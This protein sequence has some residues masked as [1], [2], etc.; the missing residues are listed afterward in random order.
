MTNTR[1]ESTHA[2][3]KPRNHTPLPPRLKFV[4]IQRE[5]AVIAKCSAEDPADVC[6]DVGE[7]PECAVGRPARW[8]GLP[9]TRHPATATKAKAGDRGRFWVK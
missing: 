5:A 4:L 1:N 8:Q 7:Q 2:R 6:Y 3:A 9:Q